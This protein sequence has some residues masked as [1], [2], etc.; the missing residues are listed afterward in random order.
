MRVHLH[1]SG[2]LSLNLKFD[3]YRPKGNPTYENCYSFNIYSLFTFSM[4]SIC[5][6]A[7]CVRFWGFSDELQAAPQ[8]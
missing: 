5:C 6:P 7:Y 4:L 2:G 8:L 1:F 3:S